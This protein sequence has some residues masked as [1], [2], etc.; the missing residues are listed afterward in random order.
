MR[1]LLGS[2]GLS[3]D[4]R[5]DAWRRQVNDFLGPVASRYW[6]PGMYFSF[7]SFLE[8]NGG[9]LTDFGQRFLEAISNYCRENRLSLDV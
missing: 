1:L 2:G 5:R 8:F 7:R 4:A 9:K 6:N 3:T